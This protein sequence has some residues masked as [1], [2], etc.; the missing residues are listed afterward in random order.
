MNTL[1]TTDEENWCDGDS[2]E[3]VEVVIDEELALIG[4]R[5]VGWERK[6]EEVG[7]VRVGVTLMTEGGVASDKFCWR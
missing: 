1:W 2:E 3:V 4:G 6:R 7:V 5:R